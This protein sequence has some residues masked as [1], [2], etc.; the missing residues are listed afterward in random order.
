MCYI[1]KLWLFATNVVMIWC[2]HASEQLCLSSWG[3]LG[4]YVSNYPLGVDFSA[5]LTNNKK[6]TPS[7]H[8]LWGSPS[9]G[10]NLMS[11]QAFDSAVYFMQCKFFLL[12]NQNS[13]YSKHFNTFI[14]I[15][16]K[17]IFIFTHHWA[18]RQPTAS[19][20]IKGEFKKKN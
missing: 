10:F 13:C 14:H 6:G 12:L 15:G 16:K 17:K 7:C 19:Q 3:L 4:Y 20:W 2:I 1:S 5:I 9:Q 11:W 18:V 8:V